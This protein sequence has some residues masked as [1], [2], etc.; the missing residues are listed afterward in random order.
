MDTWS[1]GERSA[2]A[3]TRA[4][5][6]GAVFGSV[7]LV[8]RVLASSGSVGLA[9][10]VGSACV[11]IG[12]N[13]LAAAVVALLLVPLHR[14]GSTTPAYRTLALQLS[15]ALTVLVAVQVGPMAD[16]AWAHGRRA[17]ALALVGMVFGFLGALYVNVRYWLARIDQGHP[18]PVGMAALV[19]LAGAA[20]TAIAL[21]VVIARSGPGPAGLEG[22]PS[23]V[24]ITVEGVPDG[25]VG[26]TDPVG[27]AVTPR[28]DALLGDGTRFS[29]A[30]SPST[31]PLAA[32][33]ALF[34][35]VHP[36][37]VGVLTA[38]D[39]V[40]RGIPDAVS[41]YRAEGWAT[42]A[43][44]STLAVADAGLLRGFSHRD[45][46]RVSWAPLADRAGVVGAV[47][48]ATGSAGPTW[49]ADAATVAS[50]RRWFEARGARPSLSWVHLAG[51]ARVPDPP[52][53]ARALA[54]RTAVSDVDLHLGQ[55][56]DTV[57]AQ[58]HADRTLIVVAGVPSVLPDAGDTAYG[59]LS[60]ARVRVP[61]MVW[62]PGLEDAPRG[63]APQVR[64]HDLAPTLL[65]WASLPRDDRMEGLDLTGFLDGR[66]S[67]DAF[68]TIVAKAAEGW[69]V[70][71]R[72][73][74]VKFTQHVVDG[75][76]VD[77]ALFDLEGDPA[78]AHDIAGEQEALVT[79]A[80][81][82]LG[83]ERRALEAAADRVP[84]DGFRRARLAALGYR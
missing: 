8:L 83:P 70:G 10:V 73:P 37:R 56:L 40:P 61:L 28:L 43:F 74:T 66:R 26:A 71:L 41:A 46:A 59:A 25:L 75:E 9:G 78:E 4:L 20:A 50:W 1:R 51:P 3:V 84:G 77:E 48:A 38:Q 14:A 53:P 39:T 7:E 80:R 49:R 65:A 62:M 76:V 58:P 31:D 35:G 32:H 60:D 67:Q 79:K 11:L 69:W 15:L 55:V 30:V 13:A 12:V 64:L 18:A 19:G 68:T 52:G 16:T 82:V 81:G 29:A 47:L 34:T 33:V 17:V 36:L 44:P 63:V 2:Y 23:V 54:L 72:Q 45:D 27:R 6:L 22:D 57:R 21:V 5:G 42:A 24:V